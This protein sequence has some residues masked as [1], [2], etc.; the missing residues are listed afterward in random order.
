MS[1][2]TKTK[3]DTTQRTQHVTLYKYRHNIV[4]DNPGPKSMTLECT[5]G[6]DGF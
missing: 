4:Y 3:Q 5:V 6:G 1:S 2:S